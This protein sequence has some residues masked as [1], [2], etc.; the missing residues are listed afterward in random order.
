[1]AFS[2]IVKTDCETDGALHSTNTREKQLAKRHKLVD[3]IGF[4]S[5][6]YFP[7]DTAAAGAE[8]E[9]A[10]GEEAEEGSGEESTHVQQARGYIPTRNDDF[11]TVAF[12]LSNLFISILNAL[13]RV[14]I[15]MNQAIQPTTII[16]T[17]PQL[18]QS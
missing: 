16:L 8:T 17:S 1:M 4:L 2:V 12:I 18:Y 15:S 13:R 11:P 6:L 5:F 9:A 10:A 7:Y 3:T 14:S